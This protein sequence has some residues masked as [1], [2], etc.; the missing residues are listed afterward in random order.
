MPLEKAAQHEAVQEKGKGLI[1]EQF[2]SYSSCGS[3]EPLPYL[4]TGVALRFVHLLSLVL[5]VWLR[6]GSGQLCFQQAIPGEAGFRTTLGF[7]SQA[8]VKAGFTLMLPGVPAHRGHCE[9]CPGA[10]GYKDPPGDCK[11]GSDLVHHRRDP[12][13]PPRFTLQSTLRPLLSI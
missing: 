2:N 12:W 5:L 4:L 10:L 6:S 8:L 9:H 11:V 7:D 13:V 1:S 3:R